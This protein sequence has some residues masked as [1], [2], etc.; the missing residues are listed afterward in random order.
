[1]EQATKFEMAVNLKTANQ[2]GVEITPGI[3]VR[4]DR[5]IK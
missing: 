4:A 3:L 1:V 2:I 5:V